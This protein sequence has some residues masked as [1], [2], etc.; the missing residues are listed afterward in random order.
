[1]R[2]L[3]SPAHRKSSA[4]LHPT[5][6][7]LVYLTS[8]YHPH[9]GPHF[10]ARLTGLT[11]S[12]NQV[13]TICERLSGLCWWLRLGY[14]CRSSPSRPQADHSTTTAKEA[15]F[16]IGVCLFVCLFVSRIR[17][18][19]YSIYFYKIRWTTEK[20]SGSRY[21]RVTVTVDVPRH[22]R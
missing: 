12:G 19:K 10:A 16:F 6:R 22:T 1:V 4:R 11:P 21:V 9:V 18:K 8:H 14:D 3:Y 13:V 7:R 15:M 2:Q 17:R 5:L 20:P